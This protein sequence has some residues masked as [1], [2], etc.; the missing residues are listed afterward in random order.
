MMAGYRDGRLAGGTDPGIASRLWLVALGIGL[1]F[2]VFVLRL[3]QLQ[4]LQGAALRTRSEMNFVRALPLEAPR[5]DLLDREGRVLATS[6]PAFVVGVISNELRGSDLTYRALGLLLD[7]D[8]AELAERVGSPRGRQRFQPIVLDGDMSEDARSRVE[9]HRYALPGVVTDVRPRRFYPAGEL[10]AHMLGMIGEIKSDQLSTG[11]FRSYSQGDVI[12]QSGLESRLESH[13][14]GRDGGRSVVVDVAGREIEMLDEVAPVPGGRAVLTID[15]DLQRVAE[16]AFVSDDPEKPDKMG[17]VVAVDPRTGDVLVLVSRPSY[18]PNAFARG[19]D[20]EA[21]QALAGDPWRPLQNRAI[22]GQYAPGSTYKAI[23][24]AAALAEGVIQPEDKVFCPG[25]YRLGRRVYRCWRRGGHGE[26]DLAEALAKSC[27]V[28]F[29]NAGVALGIDRI[30]QY[31][32]AFGLGSRTGLALSG[33][34]SGLVPTRAWKERARK[35]VWIKGETVSAAIGQGFNLVTPLQLAAA[36]G[37]I[38][39]GERVQPR[40]VRSLESW[41]GGTRELRGVLQREAVPVAAEHLAL[42]R[43]ALA[44]VVQSQGGTGAA[45]RVAGVRVA[46]KTGTT[47]VVSLAVI[48]QYEEDEDIPV[49]YRDHAWFAAFAPVDAPEIAIAVL[50]EHGGGGGS[51]AAPIAQRV[52]QAYFDKRERA[53]PPETTPGESP[54][55]EAKADDAQAMQLASRSVAEG[56]RA[57]H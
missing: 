48:E 12:G 17:A 54:Q 19:I 33:E 37:A 45:A 14:R 40:L 56:P 44:G 9:S 29:Y 25:Y 47:Q 27:D 51:V 22:S 28:Y 10:G 38:A 52:L 39:T 46:G 42:V 57:E 23:V 34:A 1:V 24:A 11:E 21:W 30:A 5:G 7:R 32:R 6:R 13:L 55:L 16:N 41:D 26:V 35:E 8:P 4:I 36:F 31:A 18:D 50:V 20:S 43:E 2:A 49:R 15:L 3:F 53:Q